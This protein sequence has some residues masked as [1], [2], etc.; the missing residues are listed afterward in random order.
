MTRTTD[1][2]LSL[3][4]RVQIADANQCDLFISVHHNSNGNDAKPNGFQTY[5][6]NP[7]S[8]PLAQAIQSQVNTVRPNTGWN[9]YNGPCPH[10]NFRVTRSKQ[11]PGVLLECGYMS[12]PSDEAAAMNSAH[13]QK[14]AEAVAQGVVNYYNN[15]R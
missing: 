10:Y 7:F 3:D 13:Q 4:Q 9:L 8:Q 2:Y 11:R 1:V 5:Y 6:N 12:N 15:S 14:I